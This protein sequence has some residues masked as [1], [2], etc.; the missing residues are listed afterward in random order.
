MPPFE[1]TD[2]N[3]EKLYQ[4]PI[5]ID[6]DNIVDTLNLISL[7]IWPKN[8]SMRKEF[9][10]VASISIIHSK[11]DSLNKIRRLKSKFPRK[12]SFEKIINKN[13]SLIKQ[14]LYFRSGGSRTL[15]NSP[16]V[17]SLQSIICSRQEKLYSVYAHIDF[18]IRYSLFHEKYRNGPSVRKSMYFL[19]NDG[20]S[21]LNI[22]RGLSSIKANWSEFRLISHLCFA[23]IY[24]GCRLSGIDIS[25]KIGLNHI[26]DVWQDD[27]FRVLF[28]GIA[29]WCQNFLLSFRPNNRD[30]SPIIDCRDYL[31]LPDSQDIQLTCP[32]IRPFSESDLSIICKYRANKVV[33]SVKAGHDKIDP[34]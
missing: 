15:K 3:F 29:K 34:V 9:L 19:S 26:I 16:S 17:K 11:R 10:S 27:D 6:E 23:E 5:D 28:F 8:E 18:L 7:L 4:N 21:D 30:D 2:I 22:N 20:Y 1:I 24:C 14:N 31:Y 33:D 12:K 13:I 25:S 32:V